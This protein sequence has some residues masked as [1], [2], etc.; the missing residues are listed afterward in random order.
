MPKRVNKVFAAGNT[1]ADATYKQ[2]GEGREVVN[3]SIAVNDDY[4]KDGETIKRPQFV[5]CVLYG[6]R[7]GAFAKHVGKGTA[8]YIEGKLITEQWTDDKGKKHSV[9]KIQVLDWQFDQPPKT[10]AAEKAE[11]DGAAVAGAGDEPPF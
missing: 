9:T 4:Y 8:V 6:K 3:F 5:Q 2:I 11:T 10:K 7:A 1:T